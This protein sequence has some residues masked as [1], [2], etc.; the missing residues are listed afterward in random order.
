MYNFIIEWIKF[1]KKTRDALSQSRTINLSDFVDKTKLDV[2]L[3]PYQ[4]IRVALCG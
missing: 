3:S 2:I 1:E 4:I